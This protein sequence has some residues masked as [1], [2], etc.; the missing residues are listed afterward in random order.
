MYYYNINILFVHQKS[1][2]GESFLGIGLYRHGRDKHK[3]CYRKVYLIG[4]TVTYITN[5]FYSV[6]EVAQSK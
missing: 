1:T 2:C 4:C 5:I 3:A 6:L